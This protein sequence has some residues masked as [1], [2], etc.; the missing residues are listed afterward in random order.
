MNEIRASLF[1]FEEV[2]WLG[3]AWAVGEHVTARNHDAMPE[4]RATPE[5]GHRSPETR[6]HACMREEVGSFVSCLVSAYVGT[7][8]AAG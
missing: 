5:T 7:L 4:P 2:W 1:L 8:R 6:I 3:L